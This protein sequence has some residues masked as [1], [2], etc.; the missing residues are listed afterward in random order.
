M[1]PHCRMTRMLQLRYAIASVLC[2]GALWAQ[3]PVPSAPN[4]GAPVVPAPQS[5]PPN[6]DVPDTATPPPDSTVLVI[7]KKVKPDYPASALPDKLQGQVV[8][9]VVVDEDGDVESTEVIS[10]N[11]VLAQAAVDAAK[12]WKFKPFIRN[13]KPVK[14]AIKLPFDFAPSDA[15]ANVH[16]LPAEV[17]AAQIGAIHVDPSTSGEGVR[18]SPTPPNKV[19]NSEEVAT[20]LLQAL[21]VNG[22]DAPNATPW[23]A[24]L[25]YDVFD[26]DGDN[27][28]SGSIEVFS[29]NDKKYRRVFQSDTRTLESRPLTEVATGSQLYHVGDQGWPGALELQVIREALGPWDEDRVVSPN[30]MPDKIEWK[31]GKNKLSCIIIRKRDATVSDNGLPK[32]CF[33]PGTQV[34]R[35]TRG[36]GWDETVYNNFFQF[37]GRYV[38]ADVEVT[39][40]GKPYLV[41][42]LAKVESLTQVEDALFAPPAG[43]PGPITG[44]VTLQGGVFVNQYLISR[45][46]PTYPRGAHGKVNVKFVVGKD[47]HVIEADASDGPAELRKPV[48]EAIRKWMF[49]PYFILGQPTEV[50]TN[51]M[52]QLQ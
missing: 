5:K 50:Q 21:A 10:G 26:E 37:Q 34:L 44:R 49:R 16:P 33:D 17:N 38:A 35:Y 18:F 28:H 31:V 40:S 12:Q 19:K 39:H 11:P 29:V 6:A 43:S 7:T 42:H 23:H 32:F 24:L 30:A 8:V 51:M 47:G 48:E 27:S 46:M 14:A 22:V 3:S 9:R 25:T 41:I 52:F 1:N 45:V 36:S 2:A 4:S 20:S 13:G 15:D